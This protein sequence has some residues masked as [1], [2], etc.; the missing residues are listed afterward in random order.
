M[1]G[2]ELFGGTVNQAG[3]H[4]RATR[5]IDIRRQPQPLERRFEGGNVA[6]PNVHHCICTAGNRASLDD[7]WHVGED[8][9][10]FIRRDGAATEQ[11]NIC[12]C[13][14]A[15]DGRIHL[16]REA[17]DD[18]IEYQ[19][20]DPA[21]HGRCRQSDDRADIAVTSARILAEQVEDAAVEVV[22]SASLG[23]IVAPTL[24]LKQQ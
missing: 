20:V 6:C 19:P 13:T 12:L 9:E 5:V 15:I 1:A 21:F 23:A 8:A 16:D 22:H 17:T 11:F 18:A 10:K 3:Q 7:L 24:A 4:D 2:W 14:H